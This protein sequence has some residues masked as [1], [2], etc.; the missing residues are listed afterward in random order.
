MRYITTFVT[1]EKQKFSSFT[2]PIS[3]PYASVVKLEDA[4]FQHLDIAVA[5]NVIICFHSYVVCVHWN[6][7]L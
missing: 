7:V 3:V 4:V 2:T 5:L 6:P 1:V